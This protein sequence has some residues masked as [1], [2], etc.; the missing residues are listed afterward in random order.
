MENGLSSAYCT[1]TEDDMEDMDTDYEAEVA[2][3]NALPSDVDGSSSDSASINS[4]DDYED[5]GNEAQTAATAVWVQAPAEGNTTITAGISA[6]S[7]CIDAEDGNGNSLA[8][9]CA[10]DNFAVNLKGVPVDTAGLKATA[11]ALQTAGLLILL[12]L[13]P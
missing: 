4:A 5:A 12:V 11:F 7:V 8:S 1:T 9:Q 3:A 2:E 10:S 6:S 13:V